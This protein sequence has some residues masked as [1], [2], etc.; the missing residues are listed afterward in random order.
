LREKLSGRSLFREGVRS[1]DFHP[2]QEE[3][4]E[5]RLF[6]AELLVSAFRDCGGTSESS[7]HAFT[8]R[9]RSEYLPNPY[10]NF[11]HAA[12]ILH[13]VFRFGM[14]MPWI[15][16][17]TQLEQFSLLVA[18]LSHDIGH[19][20]LSNS[21]LVSSGHD[22][23]CLYNDSSPLENM[24]CSKLFEI[25]G[26]DEC[27]VFAH[28]SSVQFALIR[29]MIIDAILNTDMAS[30][31]RCIQDLQA[32]FTDNIDVFRGKPTGFGGLT[33]QQAEALRITSNKA[34][35]HRTMLHA[36]DR[37]NA[38]KP[39][40]ITQAWTYLEI[41]EWYAEGDREKELGIPVTPMCDRD[42]G[43]WLPDQQL[44]LMTRTFAPCLA[45]QLQ[46]WPAL[47][48][49]AV[50]MKANSRE[51]Q[52]RLPTP[53]DDRRVQEIQALLEEALSAQG[54]NPDAQEEQPPMAKQPTLARRGTLEVPS[55]TEDAVS[56]VYEVRRWR[57][58]TET[59]ID[60]VKAR[61]LVLLYVESVKEDNSPDP[62]SHQPVQYRYSLQRENMASP[63][64]KDAKVH[65]SEARVAMPSADSRNVELAGDNFD[66]LY[67]SLQDTTGLTPRPLPT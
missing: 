16:F 58:D 8:G 51:W 27:N 38:S 60:G 22:L 53:Q 63:P 59:T 20:G 61:E 62:R 64:P 2:L 56:N 49:L 41:Q 50:L 42:A 31:R 1:W 24:H 55:A 28:T 30:H 3:P 52:A 9:V 32:L 39:W 26:L 57:E 23:A 46:L 34:V 47:R 36:A 4:E 40:H 45:A 10:H 33:A 14:L 54:P 12:D 43:I 37:S 18:A 25:L 67:R 21:F 19:P 11:F 15:A 5:L 13:A 29:K 66:I 44:G 7:L 48:E 65:F 6:S 35:V 17:C